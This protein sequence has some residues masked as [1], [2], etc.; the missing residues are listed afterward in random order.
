M[1][2]SLWH[3]MTIL[4]TRF[5]SHLHSPILEAPELLYE[6]SSNFL[7]HYSK[8]LWLVGICRNKCL[9]NRMLVTLNRTIT[10][11][12]RSSTL[13]HNFVFPENNHLPG[14]TNSSRRLKRLA[15]RFLFIPSSSTELT[16]IYYKTY[17]LLNKYDIWHI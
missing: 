17:N 14:Q 15:N 8:L 7:S 13:A 10:L 1:K 2:S 3:K 4:C 6:N 5:K 9:E 11:E 12:S 16:F